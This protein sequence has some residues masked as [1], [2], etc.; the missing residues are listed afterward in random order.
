MSGEALAAADEERHIR[1]APVFDHEFHCHEGL[2]VGLRVHI[3]LRAISGHVYTINQAGSV[4]SAHRVGENLLRFHRANGFEYFHFLVANTVTGDRG[5]GLHGDQRED[6]K[7]VVLD[8]VAGDSGLIVIPSSEFNAELLADGDLHVVDVA[9]VPDRLKN[10][11]SETEDHDVLNRFFSEIM[12]DAVDLGFFDALA[13][14]GIEG[15]CACEVVAEG[16]LDNDAFPCIVGFGREADEA[17]LLY[18]FAEESRSHCK[19]E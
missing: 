19:I 4:L 1:P 6:R 9:S 2:R 14:R 18:D 16:F 5:W 13:E 12:V 3:G 15:S 8:H 7:N 11:V 17:E 10:T